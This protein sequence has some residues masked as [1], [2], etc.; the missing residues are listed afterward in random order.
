LFNLSHTNFV[1]Q[2][3]KLR[4]IGNRSVSNSGSNTRRIT[5]PPQVTNH[6]CPTW[7]SDSAEAPVD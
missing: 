3:G 1:G 2:V 4:P 7:I 6:T 5:N